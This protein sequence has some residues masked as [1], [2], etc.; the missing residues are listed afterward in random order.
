MQDSDLER[1]SSINAFIIDMDGVLYTGQQ[2]LP[3][4]RMFL[5]CLQDE[6]I[7]FILATNNSTLTPQQYVAKLAGMGIEVT[8]DRI[9]TSGQAT[10]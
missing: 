6:G 5:T 4:A 1:L 7:P 3:G 2:R 9:L 8:E 10:A